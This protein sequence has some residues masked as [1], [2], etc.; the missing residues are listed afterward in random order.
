MDNARLERR[1]F[2]WD[3]NKAGDNWSSTI[4]IIFNS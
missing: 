3:Y 2:I 4:S 1:I